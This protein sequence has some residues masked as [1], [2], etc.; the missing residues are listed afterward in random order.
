MALIAYVNSAGIGMDNRQA[1]IITGQTPALD[2]YAAADSSCH[3]SIVRTWI[4]SASPWRTP[5]VGMGPRLG[6]ACEKRQTLQRGRAGPFSGASTPPINASR[7]PKSCCYAG[8]EA[9]IPYRP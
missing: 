3:Y 8:T 5:V 4:S 9:P 1:G 6:S 2:L 7:Q